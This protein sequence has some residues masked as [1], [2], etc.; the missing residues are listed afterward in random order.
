[1]TEYQE[2]MLSVCFG[3]MAGLMIGNLAAALGLCISEWKDRRHQRKWDKEL[4]ERL[5]E[6]NSEK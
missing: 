1:M 6:T 2:L 5:N 3:G 4:A